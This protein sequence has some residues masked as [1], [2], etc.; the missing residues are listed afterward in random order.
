MP[1]IYG[2]AKYAKIKIKCYEKNWQESMLT[3]NKAKLYGM[4]NHATKY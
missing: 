1:K 3:H 2:M 4:A